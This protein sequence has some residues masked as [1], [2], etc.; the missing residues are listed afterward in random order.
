MDKL[1]SSSDAAKI[2]QEYYENLAARRDRFV[3]EHLIE[4]VSKKNL[5]CRFRRWQ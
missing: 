2:A 4:P 5:C 3:E 1:I